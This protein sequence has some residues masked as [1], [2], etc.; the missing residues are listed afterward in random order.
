MTKPLH[1]SA[2]KFHVGNG[3][4]Q[5]HYWLTPPSLLADLQARYGFD[6]DACPYPKPDDFD[7]LT[8]AWGGSTYVRGSPLPERQRNGA[9]LH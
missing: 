6:F 9:P 3:S 2:N 1:P 4:D 8:T 7:G 5:K